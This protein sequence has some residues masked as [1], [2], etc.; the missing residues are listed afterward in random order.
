ML[1]RATSHLLRRISRRTVATTS[2]L[3]GVRRTDQKVEAGVNMPFLRGGVER[4][5]STER[6]GSM[7]R[8][9]AISR[10]D[11]FAKHGFAKHGLLPTTSYTPNERLEQP[12]REELCRD[13]PA[14]LVVNAPPNTGKSTA[15]RHVVRE[16]VDEQKIAGAIL[17]F[18]DELMA[19]WKKQG[20]ESAGLVSALC[21]AIRLKAEADHPLGETLRHHF[22]PLPDDISAKEA[23]SRRYMVVIDQLEDLLEDPEG[24]N[25][26]SLR[27]FVT[28]LANDAV[29]ACNFTV[30]ATTRSNALANEVVKWNGGTKVRRIPIDSDFSW[31]ED[32]VTKLSGS[33]P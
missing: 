8:D 14:F 23:L 2:S 27:H 12:I 30:V 3:F 17:V 10:V 21:Q 24:P 20:G 1:P 32:E 13:L 28:S 25:A 11:L 9:E 33:P 29:D 22:T 7:S 16:L 5:V 19:L 18:G 6:E 4:M 15:T 26:E 31:T